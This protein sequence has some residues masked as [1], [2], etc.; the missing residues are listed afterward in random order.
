MCSDEE[1]IYFICFTYPR[2][3][4]LHFLVT[5]YQFWLNDTRTTGEIFI[6]YP[7]SVCVCVCVCACACVILGPV[8]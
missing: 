1:R 5:K 4:Q 2:V 6:G 3:F 8:L 7:D